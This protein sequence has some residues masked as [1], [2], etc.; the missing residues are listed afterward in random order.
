MKRKNLQEV[1]KM[2]KKGR[3]MYYSELVYGHKNFSVSTT[4]G[5]RA[6]SVM[7]WGYNSNEEFDYRCIASC[8]L[9]FETDIVELEKHLDKWL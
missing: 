6:V 1:M 4:P 3:F 9:D 5:S 8:H 2:T 7:V